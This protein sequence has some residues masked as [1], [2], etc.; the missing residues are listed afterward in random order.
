[1]DP[2][3][4]SDDLDMTLM[5]TSKKKKKKSK[6]IDSEQQTDAVPRLDTVDTSNETYDELLERIYSVMN[7]ER[8]EDSRVKVKPP[9]VER[10]GKTKT[11]WINFRSTCE[12]LN[13]TEEH[14]QL[15][16]ASEFGTTLSVDSHGYLLIKGKFAPTYVESILRKYIDQYVKCRMCRGMKTCLERDTS[17]RLITMKCDFCKAVI[18]VE[19]IKHGFHATTKT[20]RKAARAELTD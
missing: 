10:F 18:T 11:A 12:V 15:F 2:P 5:F 17:T 4:T 14:L 8:S 9:K 16:I 6:H 13:R 20:D 7:S 1:M 19:N 3:I